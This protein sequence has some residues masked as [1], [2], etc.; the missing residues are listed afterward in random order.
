MSNNPARDRYNPPSTN[1]LDFEQFK[2]SDIS[3]DELFWLS[4][5]SNSDLNHA[6]RKIDESGALDTKTQ[7]THAIASNALVYQKI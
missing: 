4:T 5:D 6:Y 2:F 1:S 7:V 3:N